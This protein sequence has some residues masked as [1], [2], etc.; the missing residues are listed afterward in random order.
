MTLRLLKGYNRRD[1]MPH[2]YKRGDHWFVVERLKVNIKEFDEQ[3]HINSD[4]DYDRRYT[5]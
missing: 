2:I 4:F 5:I 3:T 1:K